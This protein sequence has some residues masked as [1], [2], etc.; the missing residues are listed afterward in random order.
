[1]CNQ[2]AACVVGWEVDFPRSG[3]ESAGQPNHRQ[4]EAG[5]RGLPRR[6]KY[7]TPVQSCPHASASRHFTIEHEVP[8]T[9]EDSPVQC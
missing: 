5:A 1:M 4:V 7:A 8:L 9:K 2:S 6:P 3:R